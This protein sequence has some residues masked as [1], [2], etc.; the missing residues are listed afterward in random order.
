MKKFL[1]KACIILGIA[2]VL[3]LGCLYAFSVMVVKV[4]PIAVIFNHDTESYTNP[5]PGKFTKDEL[6][7]ICGVELR[8]DDREIGNVSCMKYWNNRNV[9]TQFDDLDFYVFESSGKAKKAFNYLKRHAYSEITDE[10]KDYVVGWEA[11]TFDAT[12][13]V[14]YYIH[15]NLIIKCYVEVNSEMPMTEDELSEYEPYVVDVDKL[16]KMIRR[17]F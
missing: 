17:N 1:K 6:D 16:D 4:D 12:C 14:Y 11:D 3:A 8:E 7:E 13:K 10:G 2:I 15:S 5:H 9:P